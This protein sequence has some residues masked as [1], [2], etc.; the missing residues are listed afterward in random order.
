MDLQGMN[1]QGMQMNQQQAAQQQQQQEKNEASR[2]NM[3]S[4]VLSQEATARLNTIRCAKP[5]KAQMVENYILQLAT[6]GRLPGKMDET[7]LLSVLDQIS[8]MAPKASK[9]KFDRRRAALDSDSD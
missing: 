4:Q 7:T 8:T 5:E 9:V 6:S 1:P 3:L 2:K